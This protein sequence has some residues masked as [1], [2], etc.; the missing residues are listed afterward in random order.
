MY[1]WYFEVN[2]IQITKWNLCSA[3][4]LATYC[5]SAPTLPSIS[6]LLQWANPLKHFLFAGNK[7]L[8]LLVE[9]R[10]PHA[11]LYSFFVLPAAPPDPA[12]L[13]KRSARPNSGPPQRDTAH[14]CLPP[15]LSTKWLLMPQL[16]LICF[17]VCY[18]PPQQLRFSPGS[19]NPENVTI[20][21]SYRQ[22]LHHGPICLREQVSFDAL[23]LHSLPSHRAL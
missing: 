16:P 2:T 6:L 7:I 12:V 21:C 4:S 15:I 11:S 23:S 13:R 18:L 9:V 10:G 22:L 8:S 14:L 5:I 3:L 1:S 17:T 19:G 20:Q